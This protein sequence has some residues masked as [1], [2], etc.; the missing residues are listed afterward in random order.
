MARIALGSIENILNNKIVNDRYLMK[1]SEIGFDPYKLAKEDFDD[2]MMPPTSY[3][4]IVNYFLYKKSFYTEDNMNCY[5]SL[6]AY[7]FF[8]SGWIK[9]I[10]T[11]KLKDYI[12]LM[13]KVSKSE[14]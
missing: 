6:E 8:V 13:G 7:N 11:K 10:K 14:I 9:E 4:D 5:K 12:L 1:C 3:P 2:E